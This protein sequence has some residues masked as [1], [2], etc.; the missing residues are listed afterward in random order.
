MSATPSGPD[1]LCPACLPFG[2]L[3][4]SSPQASSTIYVYLT[5]CII[6]HSSA[7]GALG[8]QATR[9]GAGRGRDVAGGAMPYAPTVG[10]RQ[11]GV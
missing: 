6:L 5:L 4:V 1:Y 9:D 11:H 8:A 10:V 3:G 7:E 2:N